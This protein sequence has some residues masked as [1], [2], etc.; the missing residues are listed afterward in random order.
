LGNQEA[1]YNLAQDIREKTLG[2][3]ELLYFAKYFPI[4]EL[5]PLLTEDMKK[6][7]IVNPNIVEDDLKAAEEIILTSLKKNVSNRQDLY[8]VRLF[9]ETMY[10]RIKTSFSEISQL[11]SKKI[12]A[13][14]L[15]GF[16]MK[17]YLF[18]FGFA[19]N[20]FLYTT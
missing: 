8:S 20:K 5:P 9:K 3:A 12:H 2:M 1:A 4:D 6:Q 13:V 14:T 15:K 17:V 16:L 10:N 18:V 19:V 7:I 11:Q